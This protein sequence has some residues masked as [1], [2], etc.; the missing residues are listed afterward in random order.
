[1]SRLGLHFDLKMIP[2]VVRQLF[3]S[4]DL[5]HVATAS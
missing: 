3:A 2:Y 5:Q 4:V 1:M